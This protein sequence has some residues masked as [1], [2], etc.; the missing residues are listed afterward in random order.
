MANDR[1][2]LREIWEGK[3]P[4]HFKLSADETDVEP[5]EYFL[6]IPRLSY[7]P[8]VTDKVRKHFLRFVSNELQDGEM[9]MDSNGTPLKWHFPI[10]VLYDLLVGTDGTL[11]WHVTVHFSK[12][13]DD[14][15]IRCPNKEI[16]E[17]HF[18][19]SLKEADVLKHR[20]QVVSAMQKK[21]H[22]QLWLGLVNDKFDQ[23][24]AVNR[25]LME[26]IPDQD[27]FKHIPVRCYAE[28][29]TYQQ[30]LVAPS[31]ASGQKRLLQDLLDDFSTPVRKAVEAR[32]HGVTVPE[33]T[34]LQWLSEH[35]SYPDNFLHLCLSYA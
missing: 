10:G 29:G 19:S 3:I 24:W 33:S 23:F 15:L 2:I 8:L 28:D 30:K 21:D 27:G 22:N 25:R 4:V 35:L 20:G 18:M 9:W 32:T 12:F 26:P 16:V 34:P 13:P 7:F 5:E 17:A 11:P 14:I 1:E 6:L 31:T